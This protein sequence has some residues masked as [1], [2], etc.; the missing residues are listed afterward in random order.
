MLDLDGDGLELSRASGSVLFDHDADGI[1]TGTGWISSDDGILVRDLDGN[2]TIDTGREL[3]GVDTVKLN[4]QRAINGFDAL[5]DLDANADGNFTSADS[6]GAPSS[7]GATSTRTASPM[8]ASSS[9]S[10]PWASA[11]SAWSAAPPTRP[12]GPRPE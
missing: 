8:P 4:G 5:A 10:M 1:R 7:S 6:P 3:F 12:E 2:G 11:A 9:L